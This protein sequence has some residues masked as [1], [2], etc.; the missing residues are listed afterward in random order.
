M[1]LPHDLLF[2]ILL[3]ITLPTL[4]KLC[5]SNQQIN[6]ICNDEYFWEIKTKQDYPNKLRPL[7]LSWKRFYI[8]LYQG[9]IREI[10]VYIGD[11]FVQNLA[12]YQHQS[13]SALASEL[14]K[15]I[16]KPEYYKIVFREFGVPFTTIRY[17]DINASKTVSDYVSDTIWFGQ[18][19]YL[20]I[21]V[22]HLT[23]REIM[24]RS[25]VNF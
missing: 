2:E 4:A 23:E 17:I 22:V 8:A 14:L 21:K 1:L 7:N 18:N 3:K 9:E 15:N 20:S 24:G 13:I 10:P 16:E 12:V 11:I 5:P 19:N 25:K 6:T